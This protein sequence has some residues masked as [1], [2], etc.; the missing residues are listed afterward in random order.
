MEPDHKQR[1]AA[2]KHPKAILAFMKNRYLTFI[3]HY[4]RCTTDLLF[5]SYLFRKQ[6]SISIHQLINFG[7]T[8]L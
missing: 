7:L 4:S 5:V 2:A 1:T 6:A 8:F 3:L